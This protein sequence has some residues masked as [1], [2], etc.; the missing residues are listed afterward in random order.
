MPKQQRWLFTPATLPTP[1]PPLLCSGGARGVRSAQPQ[2]G[3]P[4]PGP[5]PLHLWGGARH[6]NAGLQ[7]EGGVGKWLE[8]C[9]AGLL[10][11]HCAAG[12][13][14][15]QV[16]AAP[17]STHWLSHLLT[18]C[19]VSCCPAR[20]GLLPCRHPRRPAHVV[21]PGGLDLPVLRPAQ[22]QV[23]G[24]DENIQVSYRR[25]L[26]KRHGG[27]AVQQSLSKQPGLCLPQT[28]P[29]PNMPTTSTGNL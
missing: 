9:A 14:Q 16:D 29:Q 4:Q 6:G 18:G 21:Q 2:G 25:G 22:R 7:Q 19:P 3:F 20:S 1:I 12:S 11:R 13:Q 24:G 28:F 17:L 26:R 5:Y 15:A 23:P 8:G 27:F 10:M